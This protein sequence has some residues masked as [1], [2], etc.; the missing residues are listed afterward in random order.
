MVAGDAEFKQNKFMPAEKQ[1]VTA[2]PDVIT[3]CSIWTSLV[4]AWSGVK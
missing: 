2:Y 1:I 3:V 4:S